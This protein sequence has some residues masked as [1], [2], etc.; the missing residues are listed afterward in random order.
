[1]DTYVREGRL[2]IAAERAQVD[3]P[4][5]ATAT[6]R[7][8]WEGMR[9]VGRAGLLLP[10]RSEGAPLVALATLDLAEVAPEELLALSRCYDLALVRRGRA[11]QLV[12]GH[13]RRDLPARNPLRRVTAALAE[14]STP[15]EVARV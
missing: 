6:V 12:P 1:I 8:G 10:L 3:W 13:G 7:A 15:E 2:A 11:W 4:G 9:L 14:V 5:Q